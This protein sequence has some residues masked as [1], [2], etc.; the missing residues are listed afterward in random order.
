TDPSPAGKAARP[1]HRA[2]I[3]GYAVLERC[4]A[5]GTGPAGKR[6]SDATVP[7]LVRDGGARRPGDDHAGLRRHRQGRE[8]GRG[9]ERGGRQALRGRRRGEDQGG[10]QG[11][12][13]GRQT[14]R[15]KGGR[16]AEGAG[17]QGGGRGEGSGRQGR[18]Q[19]GRGRGQD[20][21]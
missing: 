18:A 11:R 5:G 9:G 16:G 6:R 4:G 15:G 17:Q 2:R 19:R 14:C 10:A 13:R 12:G 1:S 3:R 20:R 7:T 21:A 8:E